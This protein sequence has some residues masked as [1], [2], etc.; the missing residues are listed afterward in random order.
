MKKFARFFLALV[1]LLNTA[2]VSASGL[3]SIAYPDWVFGYQFYDKGLNDPSV[4]EINVN[5][6]TGSFSFDIEYFGQPIDSSIFGVVSAEHANNFFEVND[7]S[8]YFDILNYS[9]Y[10]GYGAYYNT[11]G[12][13]GIATFDISSDT[14]F[15]EFI[16]GNGLPDPFDQT[17]GAGS[18]EVTINDAPSAV[19][20]PAA[21][22]LMLSGLGVLGFASRRRKDSV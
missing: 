18:L 1:C 22:P 10:E 14:G 19:P 2:I 6:V 15:Y 17:F 11:L 20:L 5:R 4:K 21:L 9:I 8:A 12:I 7:L 3:N 16:L 13:K